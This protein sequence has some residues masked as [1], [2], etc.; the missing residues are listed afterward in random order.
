MGEIFNDSLSTREQ[1]DL[2]TLIYY[3]AEKLELVKDDITDKQELNDWYFITINRL[4]KVCRN[5]SS[6]YSRSKVHKALPE[7]FSRSY[8]E[9]SATG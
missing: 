4:V 8:P 2:C 1:K 9:G 6:K 5:V 7:D 3:P